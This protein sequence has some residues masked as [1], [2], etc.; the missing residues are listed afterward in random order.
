MYRVT[1]TLDVAPVLILK[2]IN[3]LGYLHLIVDEMNLSYLISVIM[4]LVFVL[5]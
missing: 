2:F 5:K 1:E 3:I 4:K